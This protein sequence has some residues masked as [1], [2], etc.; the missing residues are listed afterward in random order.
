ML[1]RALKSML[2]EVK[3]MRKFDIVTCWEYIK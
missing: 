2:K 1:Y 3:L